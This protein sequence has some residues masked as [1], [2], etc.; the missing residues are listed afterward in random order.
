MRTGSRYVFTN[1]LRVLSV[2]NGLLTFENGNLPQVL[3]NEFTLRTNNSAIGP[4]GLSLTITNTTGLF[5][6][7]VTNPATGKVIKV[8][9][10]VLQQHHAGYGTFLGTNR[11][12]SVTPLEGR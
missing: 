1:G 6:G 2:T 4:N 8:G 7:S 5:Q 3:T 10:A 12:G 11:T 9:G